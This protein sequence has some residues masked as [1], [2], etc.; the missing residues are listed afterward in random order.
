MKLE[1]IRFKQPD[2]GYAPR[3]DS[4]LLAS[5]IQKFEN[6]IRG[7]KALDMGCGSGIQ[8]AALLLAGAARVTC[9]DRNPAALR[10]TEKIM[11]KQFDK[12]KINTLES[13]LFTGVKGT[14]D[15]IVFN[16]PYVPSDEIKWM[17]VDGGKKGREVIDRFLDSFP[18]HLNQNGFV[19]LLESSL[20]GRT[21]THTR[22]KKAGFAATIVARE[23]LAFEEL[24][25]YKI[26][27]KKTI[28]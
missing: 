12:S 16:P 23:K 18:P 6:E 15:V 20:N 27:R 22:M 17:E 19:L 5:M 2:N 10:A 8:T 25:V 11:A 3:E 24:V 7:K 4:W 21:I 1:D 9:V 26:E 13:N 28:L 14:F